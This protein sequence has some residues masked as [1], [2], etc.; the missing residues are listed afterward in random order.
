MHKVAL[1]NNTN[2]TLNKSRLDRQSL[3]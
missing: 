1:V 2:D 3:V